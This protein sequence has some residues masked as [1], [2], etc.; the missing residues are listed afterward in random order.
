MKYLVQNITGF[1]VKPSKK[2][3]DEKILGNQFNLQQI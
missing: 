2:I 1:P 3:V